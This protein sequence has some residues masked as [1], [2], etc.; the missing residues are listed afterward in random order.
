MAQDT[1]PPLVAQ[2]ATRT[3]RD[4][5]G[6]VTLLGIFGSQSDPHALLK[7]R[8]GKT[9]TLSRGD[10]VN[11]ETVVAIEEGRIA[12]SRNGTARWLEMPAPRS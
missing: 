9:T 6:A 3:N 4:L 12:L 2:P 1:S 7:L 8:G 5:G 11:G 10:V